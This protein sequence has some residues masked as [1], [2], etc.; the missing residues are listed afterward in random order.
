MFSAQAS[1]IEPIDDWRY[2]NSAVFA[3]AWEQ[4]PNSASMDGMGVLY[5]RDNLARVLRL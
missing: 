5:C 4:R 2:T 3:A 1:R